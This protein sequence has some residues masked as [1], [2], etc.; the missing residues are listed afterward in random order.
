MAQAT[1]LCPTWMPTDW[2][3]APGT[4]WNAEGWISGRPRKSHMRNLLPAHSQLWPRQ[5]D[6]DRLLST[7]PYL[8]IALL[9]RNLG[10]HAGP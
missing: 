2:E 6:E 10:L 5:V 1:A 3:V 8:A 4:E 7:R 9:R